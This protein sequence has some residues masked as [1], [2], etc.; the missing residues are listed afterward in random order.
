MGTWGEDN[1]ANDAALDFV[2]DLIA[3]LK[4]RIE[5]IF[6]ED[7]CSLDE[8]GE[9]E[10]MPTVAIIS[11]LCE[12]YDVGPPREEDVRRWRE[13]YLRVFDAQIDDLLIDPQSD[14][15]AKRRRVIEETFAK[16]ERQSRESWKE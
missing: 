6:E 7:T 4:R 11:L 3:S 5:E 9:A 12:H 8:D 2:G 14:F 1:F 15:K 10:L 13:Q 16:L